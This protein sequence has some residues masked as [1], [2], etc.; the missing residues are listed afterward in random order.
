MR[1]LHNHCMSY[2]CHATHNI[3]FLH[4]Q[5]KRFYYSTR[6]FIRQLVV[7]WRGPGLGPPFDDEIISHETKS[8][9][10]INN[11]KAKIDNVK[12]KI[13]DE[14]DWGP[15]SRPSL[16][17]RHVPDQLGASPTNSPLEG[18]LP[19]SLRL[20][21]QVSASHN[22]PLDSHE[23]FPY[24]TE[25]WTTPRRAAPRGKCL[26][27]DAWGTDSPHHAN[28]PAGG[29]RG[30]LAPTGVLIWPCSVAR[31]SHCHHL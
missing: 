5:I 14:E 18:P 31:P 1:Q 2:C 7:S 30:Q 24:P 17:R 13:Q 29:R 19:S 27:R 21:R 12:A 11:V 22:K 10:T 8:S 16:S 9:D 25:A 6:R 15:L 20:A 23:Q 3:S 26:Q 28:T 4:A